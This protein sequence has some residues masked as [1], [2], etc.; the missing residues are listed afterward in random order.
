ME[1]KWDFLIDILNFG[2]M[3]G[4]SSCSSW[5]KSMNEEAGCSSIG[6]SFEHNIL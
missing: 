2:T 4:K 3:V 6:V 5:G 1:G